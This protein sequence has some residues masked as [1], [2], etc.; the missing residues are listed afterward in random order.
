MTEASAERGTRRPREGRRVPAAT[1]LLAGLVAQVERL[2][3]IGRIERARLR[4][5]V[6]HA[7]REAPQ[8]IVVGGVTP[9]SAA[10]EGIAALKGDERTASIPV[11]HVTSQRA[12]CGVCSAELC[13]AGDG[14][15]FSLVTAV[16]LLLRLRHAEHD[17]ELDVSAAE[18]RL[19]SL[20]R[21]AGEMVHDFTRL[22]DVA[23]GH[24]DLTCRL[25]AGGAGGGRP[26]ARGAAGAASGRRQTVLLAEGTA[27]VRKVTRS[28]LEEL[29]Y[30]VLTAASAEEALGQLRERSKRIDLVLA[31]AAMPG[32]S[33][34]PLADELAVARP[35]ARVLLVSGQPGAFPRPFTRAGLARALNAAFGRE[36]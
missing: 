25:L 2:Q 9:G 5:L 26:A 16:R 17:P 27:A 24:V 10:V 29:G 35:R 13:V 34:G 19:A 23:T 11:L 32:L 18:A 15:A 22:L 3:P 7:A 8:A 12:P 21:L 6:A 20:G 28:L 1:V 31:D 36:G 33:G 14:G 4:D 30:D